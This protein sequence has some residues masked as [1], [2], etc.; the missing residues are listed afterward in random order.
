M[1]TN[2]LIHR[3]TCDE[4]HNLFFPGAFDDVFIPIQT[5]G[6]GLERPQQHPGSV[7]QSITRWYNIDV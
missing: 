2:L 1:K 4:W 7:Q 5:N 3:Y 6:D